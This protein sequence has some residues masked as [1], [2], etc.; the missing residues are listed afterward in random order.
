MGHINSNNNIGSKGSRNNSI[1]LRLQ[2]SN[3]N[4]MNFTGFEKSNEIL[5]N[6][7]LCKLIKSRWNMKKGQKHK[8]LKQKLLH[9]EEKKKLLMDI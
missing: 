9:T 3:F 7:R 4:N 2:K 8:L 5:T 6:M 1:I